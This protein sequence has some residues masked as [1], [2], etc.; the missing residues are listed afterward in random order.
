MRRSAILRAVANAS[1]WTIYVAL[2]DEGV[3]TFVGKTRFFDRRAEEFSE[4][5]GA[6]LEA[7][8]EIE[9]EEESRVVE[10]FVLNEVAAGRSWKLEDLRRRS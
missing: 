5:W 6:Q 8:V 7:V 1:A 2:N 4:R 9:G 3:A 10:Q